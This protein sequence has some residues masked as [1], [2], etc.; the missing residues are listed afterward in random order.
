MG[1]TRRKSIWDT[2]SSKNTKVTEEKQD[3]SEQPTTEVELASSPVVSP[4]TVV[5]QLRVAAERKRNRSWETENRSFLIR[6]VPPKLTTAIK[7][8]AVVLNVRTDDV[9]RAFF[10]FGLECHQK[11]EINL[12]PVLSNQRLTLFPQSGNS[13]Q[14]KAQPGWVEKIL[15]FQPPAK[16]DRKGKTAHKSNQEKAW[17]WQVS[18]RG[19]PDEVK[20]TLRHLHQRH[21]VPLGEVATSLLGHSLEAYQTGRLALVPQPRI[22]PSLT[23]ETR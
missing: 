19:I 22:A 17:R 18:Y 5:E 13:W 11:G 8:I 3:W 1:R 7:E 2:P 12:T 9:A 6:G 21:S 23:V 20:T 4:K 15:D 10:E 16:P 14:R